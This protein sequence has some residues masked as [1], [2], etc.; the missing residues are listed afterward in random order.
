MGA[1]IHSSSLIA[2]HENTCLV[3]K[4]KLST[5]DASAM[6]QNAVDEGK[7]LMESLPSFDSAD[8]SLREIYGYKFQPQHLSD[9]EKS[10]IWV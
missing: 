1:P 9:I 4:L 3:H 8:T 5:S 10:V 2:D 7:T 6:M